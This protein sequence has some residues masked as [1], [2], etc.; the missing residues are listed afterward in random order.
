ADETVGSQFN[1]DHKV[2]GTDEAEKSH[3]RPD[4]LPA[5]TFQEERHHLAAETEIQKN[6]RHGGDK[7][8]THAGTEPQRNTVTPAGSYILGGIAG[9]T[10][11]QRHEGINCKGVQLH[12]GGITGDHRGTEAVHNILD[13]KIPH[14]KNALLH[15]T[16]YRDRRDL[17]EKIPVKQG[18]IFPGELLQPAPKSDKG[19]NR[20]NA[21]REESGPRHAGYIPVKM[22]HKDIVQNDIS[23][24]RAKKEIQRRAGIAKGRIYAGAYIVK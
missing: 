22:R 11:S 7:R 13:K 19:K 16:G 23:R 9:K 8:K 14:G 6:E 10:A 5:F 20:G 3:P 1:G 18:G 17:A 21:L 12:A 15:D 2:A 24:G 4:R